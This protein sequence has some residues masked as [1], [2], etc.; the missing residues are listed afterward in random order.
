MNAA[1]L[2][3]LVRRKCGRTTVRVSGVRVA[4]EL[5]ERNVTRTAPNRLW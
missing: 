1:G 2:S 4:A 5:V 3:G